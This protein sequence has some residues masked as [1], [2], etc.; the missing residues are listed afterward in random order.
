MKILPFLILFLTTIPCVIAQTLT[1]GPGSGWSVTIPASTITEAGLDYTQTTTT[2]VTNQSLMNVTGGILTNPKVYVQKTD[3][4]WNSNLSLLLRRTGAGTGLVAV[5]IAG[6][7][8]FQQITN[9]P[10][11]FFDL[12]TVAPLTVTSRTNIPIQYEI[13]GLSVLIP[14]QSYTTTILYTVTY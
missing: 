14:A 1:V 13:R 12:I 6:G 3:V 5:L 10:L 8:T 7:T 9:S 4:T 11:Y 2:S